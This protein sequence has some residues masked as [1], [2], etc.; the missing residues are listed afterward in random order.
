VLR[1]RYSSITIGRQ[2][3]F[4]PPQAAMHQHSRVTWTN[5]H[6]LCGVGDG[7]IGDDAKQYRLT[8]RVREPGHQGE[9]PI[10]SVALFELDVGARAHVERGNRRCHP[11]R[12]PPPFVDNPPVSDR[13]QPPPKVVATTLEARQAAGDVDPHLRRDV[14]GIVD[15]TPTHVP[16]QRRLMSPPQHSESVPVALTSPA[17]R[18]LEI[19]RRRDHGG[20]R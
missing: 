1:S 14:L 20:R 17:K 18:A 7:Q 11:A 4:E 5:L 9:R 3:L 16:Q 2:H 19:L 12:P 6:H 15:A 13:E 8:H 10:E